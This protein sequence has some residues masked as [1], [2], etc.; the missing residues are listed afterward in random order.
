MIYK[1]L[2]SKNWIPYFKP[3][4]RAFRDNDTAI[5]LSE[6]ANQHEDYEEK[7]MLTEDG[8]FFCTAE[9]LEEQI[10]I[11]NY[12]QSQAIDKLEKAGLIETKLKG[13]PAKRH[14]RFPDGFESKFSN[15][16]KTGFEIPSKQESKNF[17]NIIETI[18]KK[19]NKKDIVKSTDLTLPLPIETENLEDKKQKK[20]NKEK[21]TAEKSTASGII[22]YL[23]EKALRQ[24]PTE[25]KRADSNQKIIIAR[26][27]DGF[28]EDELKRVIDC[29]VAK[30]LDDPKMK[31]YLK[32]STLFRPGHCSDYLE[33][34]KSTQS[35]SKESNGLVFDTDLNGQTETYKAWWEGL[36]EKY[37]NVA[38]EIR[39]MKASEFKEFVSPEPSWF[40]IY[41]QRVGAEMNKK[42]I[43]Q[44]LSDLESNPNRK[45]VAEG[46]LYAHLTTQLTEM[47]L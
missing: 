27:R 12:K 23:N 30:W 11:S 47:A 46:G 6:L 39:F 7:G 41:R 2:S 28:T 25:G 16:L 3:L 10:F 18:I 42:R 17:E 43:N 36:K 29:K 14:F 22:A 38:T 31:D 45:R 37:P 33:E 5:L 21:P 20:T 15:F 1:L 9:K 32:P 19:P 13:V 35:F 8:Y 44:V 26:L 24:F 4:A 40:P 34:S